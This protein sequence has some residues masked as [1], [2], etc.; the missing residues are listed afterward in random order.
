MKIVVE[1]ECNPVGEA[2]GEMINREV[3]GHMDQMLQVLRDSQVVV[4]T[5]SIRTS[6]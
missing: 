1:F 5:V 3:R 6:R 4:A 2:Q